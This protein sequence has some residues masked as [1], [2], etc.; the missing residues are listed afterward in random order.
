MKYRNILFN[1]PANNIT[2]QTTL[3]T[4]KKSLILGAPD[5]VISIPS[6]VNQCQLEKYKIL[7]ART[8]VSQSLFVSANPTVQISRIHCVDINMQRFFLIGLLMWKSVL[9]TTDPA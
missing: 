5:K 1:I 6:I 7:D 3:H 4:K 2:F 8:L 9:M